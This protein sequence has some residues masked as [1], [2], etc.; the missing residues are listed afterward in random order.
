MFQGFSDET[1]E[2]FMAIRFNNNRDFFQANRD[3]YLRAVREPCLRLAV[4]GAPEDHGPW[5]EQRTWQGVPGRPMRVSC[6]TNLPEAELFLNGVSLGR[7]AAGASGCRITWEV[8]YQPG[9]LAVRSGGL[10]DRLSTPFPAEAVECVCI[11]DPR[12]EDEPEVLQ[13]EVYL[14][15]S[16]GRPAADEVI[17]CQVTGDLA[18]M[19]MENGR[20]DDLTPYSASARSTL[21]GRMILYLRKTG[22]G[23]SENHLYLRTASGL[24]KKL[25]L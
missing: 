6:Y 15:D 17:R 25:C 12:R 7:K 2:F 18:L 8:P 20:P 13:A 3:W 24:E 9:M 11:R 19:G 16:E 23:S 10:E 22:E 14:K 5:D 1:F 21:N 4:S